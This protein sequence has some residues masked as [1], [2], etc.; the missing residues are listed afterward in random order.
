MRFSSFRQSRRNAWVT[1][2]GS[3]GVV[4]VGD[5]IGSED[6]PVGLAGLHTDHSAIDLQSLQPAVQQCHP[7]LVEVERTDLMGLRSLHPGVTADAVLGDRP[8]LPSGRA[9]P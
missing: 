9:A 2:E 5:G 7:D 3:I 1:N 4:G 8:P 6:E